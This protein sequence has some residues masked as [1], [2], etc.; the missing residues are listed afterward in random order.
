[1]RKAAWD[2]V[3]FSLE[4]CWPPRAWAIWAV[5]NRIDRCFIGSI[6]PKSLRA[7]TTS[8]FFN[9]WSKSPWLASTRTAR[10][11]SSSDWGP[12]GVSGV[13][14]VL[15]PPFLSPLALV[16]LAGSVLGFSAGLALGITFALPA[17]WLFALSPLAF[18]GVVSGITF[19][20][21]A[22]AGAAAES[23][24]AGFCVSSPAGC[25]GGVILGGVALFPVAAPEPASSS[26]PASTRTR[27]SKQAVVVLSK[28]FIVGPLSVENDQKMGIAFVEWAFILRSQADR[29]Q[30]WTAFRQPHCNHHLWYPEWTG[31]VS[32]AIIPRPSD[33]WMP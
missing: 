6:L 19:G 29:G 13:L 31:T 15:S 23:G 11:W 2:S 3:V 33:T 26:Q 25:V 17:G 18:S 7:S 12:S 24:L 1:M 16:F 20:L 30:H 8:I 14:D 28:R 10:I 5:M 22:D 32:P 9:D 21:S 27:P 4:A